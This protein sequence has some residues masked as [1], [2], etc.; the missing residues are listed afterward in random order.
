MVRQLPSRVSRAIQ[1]GECH[2]GSRAKIWRTGTVSPVLVENQN[3]WVPS[4]EPG[5]T[6]FVR[7]LS[8]KSF[9]ALVDR[10]DKT[11]LCLHLLGNQRG[12]AGVSEFSQFWAR[13]RLV[14]GVCQGIST[15]NDSPSIEGKDCHM[16]HG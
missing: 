9:Q 2:H 3:P 8:K 1:V 6:V 12:D 15:L 5:D 11:L 16:R 7:L 10:R 14:R 4:S 13:G